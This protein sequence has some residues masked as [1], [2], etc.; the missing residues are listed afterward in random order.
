MTR[1]AVIFA[2]V[3]AWAGT[4]R[5]Q[6]GTAN[7]SGATAGSDRW[8]AEFTV[9]PTF[10]HT[11]SV[12]FGGELGWWL[13][14]TI[15]IFGEGGRMQNVA[16]ADFDDKAALIANFIGGSADARRRASYFDAGA[17]YKLPLDMLDGR[18][19]PYVL[20]GVGGAHVSNDVTFRVGGS[21]V[22]GSLLDQFGV[23]LGSDLAGTYN[24]VFV[25]VGAGVHVDLTG[26]WLADISYRYGRVGSNKDA[27]G[28][29]IVKALNTNRLQ[30]GVG[31]RF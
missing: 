30:L 14:D 3:V 21:D 7:P 18:G 5:A 31:V 26:R 6:A 16:T 27:D 4:A 2:V 28:Q 22:T 25:T 29:V 10:G 12:S 1:V 8:Y 17:V 19:H 23:Q 9:G 20:A 15:G 13:T 24:K 11:T